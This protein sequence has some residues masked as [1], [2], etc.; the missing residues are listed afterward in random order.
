MITI[1]SLA[2]G[3]LNIKATFNNDSKNNL[4]DKGHRKQER[5]LLPEGVLRFWHLKSS[6]FCYFQ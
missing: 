4:N 3:D 6:P 5:S 2:Y 1:G